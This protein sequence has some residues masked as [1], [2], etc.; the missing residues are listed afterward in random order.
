MTGGTKTPEFRTLNPAGLI[1]VLVEESGT[2]KFILNESAAILTYLAEKFHDLPSVKGYYPAQ[3]AKGKA[4]ISAALHW[5]H[6]N[7]RKLTLSV[8]RPILLEKAFGKARDEAAKQEAQLTLAKVFESLERMLGSS[9]F[10]MGASPTIVDLQ[11]Y[12]EIDQLEVLNLVDFSTY[13][14]VAKWVALMKTLP[15]YEA[16]HKPLF[17]FASK[18]ASK[19]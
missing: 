12:C 7:T 2:E 8:F 5:H 18:F 4:K 15:G 10:F 9:P 17:E 1:P 16:S 11:Y 13:P 3:C 19:L 6:H 14:K